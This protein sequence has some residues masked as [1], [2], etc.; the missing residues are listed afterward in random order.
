VYY[1]YLYKSNEYIESVILRDCF[2]KTVVD[3]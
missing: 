3:I 1:A 2:N